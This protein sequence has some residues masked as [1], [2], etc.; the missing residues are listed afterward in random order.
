MSHRYSKRVFILPIAFTLQF[1]FAGCR[2]AEQSGQQQSPDTPVVA[3]TPIAS[4]PAP[5]SQATTKMKP[6]TE[7]TTAAPPSVAAYENWARARKALAAVAAAHD[8]KARAALLVARRQTSVARL[9]ASI[10]V[11]KH[12]FHTAGIALRMDAQGFRRLAVS[13]SLPDAIRKGMRA[14]DTAYADVLTLRSELCKAWEEFGSTGNPAYLKL[15]KQAN[16]MLA[17]AEKGIHS[18]ESATDELFL[19]YQSSNR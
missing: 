10:N 3:A 19:L 13:A 11:N 2:S 18:V 12:V 5:S 1:W 14:V 7:G 15:I 9:R 17:D 8:G 4:S 6:S 16:G